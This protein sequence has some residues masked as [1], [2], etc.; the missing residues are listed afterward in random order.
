VDVR[1]PPSR[2]LLQLLTPFLEN[3]ILGKPV[4]ELLH[5]IVY[6]FGS[7]SGDYAGDEYADRSDYIGSER[8]FWRLCHQ[9]KVL[10]WI[11]TIDQMAS[12]ENSLLRSLSAHN[13]GEIGSTELASAPPF[14][15]VMDAGMSCLSGDPMLA[16]LSLVVFATLGERHGPD[17]VPSLALARQIIA[18][19]VRI[20]V[21]MTRQF[22]AWREWKQ[23][24]PLWAGVLVEAA[25]WHAANL[26]DEYLIQR[27]ILEVLSDD[28]RR[29]RAWQVAG[30]F[31]DVATSHAHRS[32]RE[33]LV[34]GVPILQPFAISKVTKP[35]LLPIPSSALEK[36]RGVQ[37]SR[38]RRK[39]NP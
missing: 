21:G 11:Y 37:T 31:S 33:N 17:F 16:G 10:T 2:T 28:E 34:G 4:F 29:L 12:F 8:D 1:P 26:I 27:K 7:G 39:S 38:R 3:P 14:S 22:E 15:A 5:D 35:T 13:R 9:E 24:S 36:V 25:P 32:P 20:K 30:W 19:T 18:S 23:Y 6:R